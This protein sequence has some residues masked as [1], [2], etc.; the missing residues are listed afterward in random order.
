MVQVARPCPTC[1]GT[2][3]RQQEASDLS[4]LETVTCDR[5]EGGLGS[6]VRGLEWVPLSELKR[7]LAES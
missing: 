2:G 3:Q 4:G 5:C 6:G 7:L 1:R